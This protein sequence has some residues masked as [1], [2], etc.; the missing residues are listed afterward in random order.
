MA[1]GLPS[2]GMEQRLWANC[3]SGLSSARIFH[4]VCIFMNYRWDGDR[5]EITRSAKEKAALLR[6]LRKVEGQVRGLQQMIE[7]DRYCLEVMQQINAIS[8]ALRAVSLQEIAD[9]LRAGVDHAVEEH[10]GDEAVEEILTVLRAA[11][12][13][14]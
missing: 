3:R 6:R 11:M 8:A 4:R 9:H 2:C 5:L 14:R 13:S 12:R 1:C 7:D 10:D